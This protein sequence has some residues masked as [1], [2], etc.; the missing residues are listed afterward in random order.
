MAYTHDERF[1]L[2]ELKQ[3]DENKDE[4]TL[5]I[6]GNTTLDEIINSY[7]GNSTI[8]KELK[9]E[10]DHKVISVNFLSISNSLHF[11]IT[12]HSGH[13]LYFPHSH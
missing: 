10:V 11:L 13:I 3:S 12:L 7:E 6:I 1:V 8:Y 9:S 5:V 4:Y 2:I